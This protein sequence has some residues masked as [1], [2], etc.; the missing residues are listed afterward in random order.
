MGKTSK[1]LVRADNASDGSNITEKEDKPIGVDFDEEADIARKVLK[2]LITSSGKG[3]FSSVEDASQVLTRNEESIADVSL[4]VPNKLNQEYA[5]A[6]D[7]TESEKSIKSK[8]SALK[9]IDG[10]DLHRT[11][12]ISNLPFDIENEEVRH[13]FSSFGEVESFYPALHQ[14]TKYGIY[15]FDML[16]AS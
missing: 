7:V 3:T 1:H 14:V 8:G 16:Y 6:L 13:R 12:F 15:S 10:E 4:D 5:K 9:N 11:I 2:N